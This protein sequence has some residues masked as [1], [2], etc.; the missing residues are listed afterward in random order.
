MR[1]STHS[2]ST[3]IRL[4]CKF[5]AETTTN[6]HSSLLLK[7]QVTQ[8][9]YNT[10]YNSRKY[11]REMILSSRVQIQSHWQLEKIEGKQEKVLY[12]WALVS[13]TRLGKILPT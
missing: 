7:S 10:E 8:K 6:H 12:K 4:G 3:H 2:E 13:V 11:N 1:R 5:V 9:E